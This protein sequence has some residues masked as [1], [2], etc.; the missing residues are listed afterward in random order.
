MRPFWGV[1]THG[2]TTAYAK[3]RRRGGCRPPTNRCCVDDGAD[4]WAFG[5][6]AVCVYL[7]AAANWAQQDMH[8]VAVEAVGRTLDQ[9]KAWAFWRHGIRGIW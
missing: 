1:F 6:W 8:D 9:Q 4:A 5:N 3:N 7:S 2:L